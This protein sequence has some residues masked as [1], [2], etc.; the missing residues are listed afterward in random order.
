[1]SDAAAL[2]IA[3]LACAASAVRSMSVLFV[4]QEAMVPPASST[5]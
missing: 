3:P 5:T 1:L 4:W 2:I